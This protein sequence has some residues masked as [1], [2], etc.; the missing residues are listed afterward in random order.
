VDGFAGWCVCED[1]ECATQEFDEGQ[2]RIQVL[3]AL[4]HSKSTSLRRHSA[5]VSRIGRVKW[6][7]VRHYR[8]GNAL[9]VVFGL[10]G[11]VPLICQRSCD[12]VDRVIHG[13]FEE[14]WVRS[15]RQRIILGGNEV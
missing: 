13:S 1:G 4:W 8:A 3:Y 10:R 7:R 5:G 15:G 9:L 2:R 11:V 14:F 12:V 6:S